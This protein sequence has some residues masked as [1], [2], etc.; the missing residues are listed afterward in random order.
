M[1]KRDFDWLLVR[2][3]RDS[4]REKKERERLRYQDFPLMPLSVFLRW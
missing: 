4:V 3:G 1:R 2:V